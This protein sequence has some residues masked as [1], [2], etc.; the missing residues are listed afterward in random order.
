MG[1]SNAVQEQFFIYPNPAHNLISVHLPYMDSVEVSI[2]S[3]TGEELLSRQIK[4]TANLD[5]SHLP[6]GSYTV[7]ISSDDNSIMSYSKL[8]IAK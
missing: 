5:I 7:S 4:Q 8:I 2:I 6:A 1:V 3:I